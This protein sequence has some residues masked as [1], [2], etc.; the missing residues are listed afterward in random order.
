M[1]IESTLSKPT[2]YLML[3]DDKEKEYFAFSEQ[4]LD[5]TKK[6]ISKD[7]NIVDNPDLA[8]I[9]LLDRMIYTKKNEAAIRRTAQENKSIVVLRD[10]MPYARVLTM[11]I[12]T[13]PTLEKEIEKIR[14][15]I[16]KFKDGF[17]EKEKEYNAIIRKNL[18]SNAEMIINMTPLDE[19]LIMMDYKNLLYGIKRG[20]IRLTSEKK[21]MKIKGVCETSY[22]LFGDITHFSSQ[23]FDRQEIIVE[24]TRGISMVKFFV[25]EQYKWDTWREKRLKRG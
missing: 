15:E 4:H 21:E 7:F 13:M 12:L 14:E 10:I 5:K 2:V 20:D 17:L 6:L 23:A 1:D 25:N 11:P 16:S 24:G 9:L 8:Y 3:D 18:S 22:D 19:Q